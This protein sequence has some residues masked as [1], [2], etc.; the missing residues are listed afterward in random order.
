MRETVKETSKAE[1]AESED[2][3]Y[4]KIKTALFF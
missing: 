1:E 3:H 2:K 4:R